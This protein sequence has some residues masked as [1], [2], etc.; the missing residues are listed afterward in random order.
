MIRQTAA[1][2]VQ[3]RSWRQRR[4]LSQLVL[5]LD[6]GTSQRH[7]SFLESERAQPS[8]EMVLRLSEAL[9][10]PLRERNNLL[11]AAG[12]APAYPHRPL[13]APDLVAARSTIEHILEGH[14]PHPALA[15]DRYWTLLSA[16][17]ALH[18][19]LGELPSHQVAAP[20]NVLRLSLHPE[21]LGGRILNFREWRA[22]VLSRLRHEAEVSA[23]PKLA[24]LLEE[25]ESGPAPSRNPRAADRESGES[26]IAVPLQLASDN[27]PLSFISTT[28]V[29]GT[30]ADVTLAEITIETFF[31]A[32]RETAQAMRELVGEC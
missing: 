24:A 14:M 27:G 32:D 10:L 21:G 17:R 11:L 31:P 7:L 26:R 20:L 6:A 28:T 9:A 19:L 13:E 18:C 1:F 23:D 8:R 16:N 30:A 4:R 15:V 22:H 25:L 3:L 29:F 5:A 2:G 12:F